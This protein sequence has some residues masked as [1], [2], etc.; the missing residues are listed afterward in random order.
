MA[1]TSQP[2][3][4]SFAPDGA[5]VLAGELDLATI[6]ELRDLVNQVMAPGRAIV[7]DLAQLT[8]IDSSAIHWFVEIC[9]ETGHPVILRN[10]SPLVRRILDIVARVDAD[11]DAWIYAD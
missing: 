11:G 1:V 4:T 10:T 8:F 2:F 7:F 9:D 3:P 5:F 6:R